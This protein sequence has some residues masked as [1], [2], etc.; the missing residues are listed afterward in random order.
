MEK[1]LND[2]Q[3]AGRARHLQPF[4]FSRSAGQINGVAAILGNNDMLTWPEKISFG[5]GLVP[6]MLRGQ[7]YV[8]ECDKY[9]GRS[10]CACTTFPSA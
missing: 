9:C 1:P 2:L 10:G 8:E 5:L 4:R 6:A 3:P 7:G